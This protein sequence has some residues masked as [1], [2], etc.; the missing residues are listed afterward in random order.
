[1]KKGI[2]SACA[3]VAMA[4]SLSGCTGS[5]KASQPGCTYQYVFVPALSVSRWMNQ[6]GP[7]QHSSAHHPAFSKVRP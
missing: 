6:C 3:L 5:V 2:L 1:M 7:V 4:F